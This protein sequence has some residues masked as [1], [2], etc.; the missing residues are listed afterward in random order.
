MRRLLVALAF[1]LGALF[2]PTPSEVLAQCSCGE[3]E[4]NIDAAPAAALATVL[5]RSEDLWVAEVTTDIKG[6]LPEQV[7][8]RTFDNH[9]CQV[10]WLAGRDIAVVLDVSVEGVLEADGC[11]QVTA[12]TLTGWQRP[13][14]SL[15]SIDAVAA[16]P[17]GGY[18]VV[19]VG[20]DGSPRAYGYQTGTVTALS[21]C[22]GSEFM[23]EAAT[24]SDGAEIAVRSLS[25]FDVIRRIEIDPDIETSA[26]VC[27]DAAADSI[28]V[29][30]SEGAQPLAI[31]GSLGAVEA[32]LPEQQGGQ[33]QTE[34]AGLDP[35]VPAPSSV[36]VLVT[37][38]TLTAAPQDVEV[39]QLALVDPPKI[40]Q[41][42]G[43][44]VVLVVVGGLAYLAKKATDP[45]WR[46]SWSK[47]DNGRNSTGRRR[48]ETRG[49]G[50]FNG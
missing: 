30:T 6:N 5:G 16:G 49:P 31:D 46:S 12:A 28:T 13:T 37:P 35:S 38:A 9:Q 22:P 14:G 27:L 40:G 41:W 23:V 48:E 21:V 24:L 34:L 36:V 32:E 11:S 15:G 8:I 39:E 25:T 3:S 42:S 18:R 20:P 45:E 47:P 44:L 33:V 19:A 17:W 10:D 2:I 26:V 4:P 50:R 1:V 29:V 43:W 7:S